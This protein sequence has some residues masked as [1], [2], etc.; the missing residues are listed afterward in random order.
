M[1]YNL[2]LFFRNISSF[3]FRYWWLVIIAMLIH[4][5]PFLLFIPSEAVIVKQV[6][7]IAAYIILTFALLKNLKY[8]GICLIL[9]GVLLNFAAIAFNAGLMPVSPG[10]LSSA[11]LSSI[12]AVV[13]GVLPKGS[14]ILLTIQQTKLWWLTD[15]IPV[16]QMRLVCSIG[17]LIMLV[18]II[19][20]GIQIIYKAYPRTNSREFKLVI[21][22]ASM[23]R[24]KQ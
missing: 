19:V 10:A 15:I 6:A 13:G 17:D 4:R 11:N 18:G 1:F 9:A 16:R 23:E 8:F 20:L 21:D 3:K 12:G 2:K 7:M 14:G 5:L 22:K 24:G